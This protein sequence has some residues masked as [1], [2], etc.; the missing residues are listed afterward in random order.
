M[1]GMAAMMAANIA[2]KALTSGKTGSLSG[3]DATSIGLGG[4]QAPATAVAPL[5]N[6]SSGFDNA[7]TKFGENMAGRA[8]DYIGGKIFDRSPGSRG[9][10]QKQYMDAA[11]PGTN[12]WEQLGTGAGQG[13]IAQA[14]AGAKEQRNTEREKMSTSVRIAE[15]G[16]D[17]QK[18]SAD[19]ASE[20]PRHLM[21]SQKELNIR[22]GQREVS[23]KEL[24]EGKTQ[25]IAQQ[26]DK[27]KAEIRQINTTTEI[28]KVVLEWKQKVIRADI[29]TK[30]HGN[31]WKTIM[32]TLRNAPSYDAAEKDLMRLGAF[33]IKIGAG[34]VIGWGLAKIGGKRKGKTKSGLNKLPHP[35]KTKYPKKW[36]KNKIKEYER[37]TGRIK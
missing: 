15:I 35:P 11:H 26:M 9:K 5:P 12:P 10:D 13:G 32:T 21:G 1:W 18:Y 8:G 23:G 33:L 2:S 22:K 17:A 29:L 7:I 3:D 30:E 6:E 4:G 19:R 36:S 37:D 14:T 34:G 27:M 20:G 24:D 31:P 16:A 28:E 25:L